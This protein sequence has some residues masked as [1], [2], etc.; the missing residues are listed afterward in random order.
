MCQHFLI[1]NH[2]C[3]L[4]RC[5]CTIILFDFIFYYQYISNK[6]EGLPCQDFDKLKKTHRIFL[7]V[8]YNGKAMKYGDFNASI[9]T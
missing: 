7:N 5:H 2:S 9:K 8:W 4:I 3:M 1:N 6:K